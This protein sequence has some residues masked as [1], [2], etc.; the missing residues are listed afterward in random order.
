MRFPVMAGRGGGGVDMVKWSTLATLNIIG[1]S[2]FGYEFRAR[3]HSSLSGSSNTEEKY[4]LELAYSYNTILDIGIHWT[5]WKIRHRI[6]TG[7][8]STQPGALLA[9]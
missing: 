2:G 8:D 1:S 7:V 4:S 6:A 5:E 3:D 9:C